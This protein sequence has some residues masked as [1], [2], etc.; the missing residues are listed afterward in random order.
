MKIDELVLVADRTYQTYES[1]DINS[2]T[3]EMIGD[4]YYFE[5]KKGLKLITDRFTHYNT[6]KELIE[7]ISKHKNA[8]VFTVYG[9]K[10]SR[11][12]MALIPAI[13][14]SYSVKYVGADVYA[15]ILCQDKYISK[16]FAKRYGLKT[17]KSILID[18]M[19]RLKLIN[20]LKLPL[21][22]KPNFEGSSIGITNSRP[23]DNYTD[24]SSFAK[25]MFYEFKQPVLVEE[26]IFGKEVS[27]SIVGT[28]K[29]LTLFEAMEIQYVNTPDFFIDKIYTAYDK[30][31]ANEPIIHKKCTEFLLQNETKAI[32]ELFFSLGKMD[33]MRIDGRLSQDGFYLIEL[34]PDA[35]I[36][37]K[38]AIADAGKANGMDYSEVLYKIIN[39]ALENYRIPYSNYIKN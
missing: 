8:I 5:I 28:T 4:E 10:E 23:Y 36:G 31:K 27:I 34:T 3:L 25:K 16:V 33:F 12:R 17:P 29:E 14:E 37:E 7:N 26:F 22:I 32:K 30:H 39:S 13:C 1:I 9:G 18:K 15:R 2:T 11:N 38:S 19:S 20:D 35:Y 6:P 21:I 24:A